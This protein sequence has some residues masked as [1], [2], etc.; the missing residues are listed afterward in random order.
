MRELAITGNKYSESSFN[1]FVN[2]IKI[3]IDNNFRTESDSTKKSTRTRLANPWITQG[4]IVSVSKK[5]YLYAKGN[6]LKEINLA[7]LSVMISTRC[8]VKN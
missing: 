7:A 8:I 5:H 2:A 3:K 1:I 4:I 6:K